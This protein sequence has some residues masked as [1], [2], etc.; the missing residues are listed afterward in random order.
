M[1]FG[2]IFLAALLAVL[3]GGIVS[4]LFWMMVVAG[5]MGS[6]E[7]Q[8][9]VEENS[10]LQIDFTEQI[11]D[12]PSSDPLS[13][14]DFTTLKV[15]PS[16]SLYQVLQA[17]DAARNDDRIKG[18]YIRPKGVG[19]LEIAVLEELRTALKEFKQS[20]KF[21]V[22]YGEMY[23]QG[24]YYLASVADKIFLQK[25]GMISWQGLAMTTVFFKGLFD[26]LGIEYEIY[27]PTSCKYK[28]AVEPYFLK[29]MS[30]P[31]REQTQQIIDS[32]WEVLASD[33]AADRGFDL[34]QFNTLTD[35]LALSMP[36]DALKNGMV[37]GLI[38][39]DEMEAWFEEQGVE[40][41]AD[42]K[43]NFISLGSY[44]SQLAPNIENLTA[45]QVAILYA[46][47]AI[48][49]G[50]GSE[51]GTIYGNTLAAEVAALRHNEDVK[52][53][54]LRV[55]SPGGSALASDVIWREITLLQAQKP[56]IISMGSYAASGGYYISAPADAILANRLTLTG[57]IGVFGAFPIV[58]EMLE[59][60]LG[61]TLDG[62]KSNTSGDFGQT[63]LIGSSRPSTPLEKQLFTRSVDKVY[64]SFTTK[65]ASGRNLPL[66]R[67]LEIAEGRVW[68]GVDALEI[69]LVD[70]NGG[71]K[72]AIA[73][74]A[75]KAGLSDYRVEEH[76]P[77]A[78]GLSAILS[79][80]GAHI[81]NR[82]ELNT[83]GEALL[84]YKK[85]REVLDQQGLLMYSPYQ[86]S[87][88]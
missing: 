45:P 37:D 76:L 23:E 51:S 56:V 64:E 40:R 72:E 19:A 32:M 43:F 54:V 34:A 77:A 3:V 22:A 42:R 52:A 48:V 86:Y 21:I 29:E 38:Y 15:T 84:P 87:I 25:E 69:G 24:H 10:I 62:V 60:K 82:F 30:Q 46:D 14:F 33:V 27:R 6:M 83:L 4:F 58:G 75:E 63:I 31:N 65:V 81:Q 26:K 18:I 8:P 11:S 36:A 70:G 20:G 55:N 59:K 74:A 28:S 39:E 12:A 50:E 71:L 79:S 67:V 5:F 41:N 68:S 53:V 57:S 1:K 44:A 61:I 47:G 85:A 17:V 2:K 78:D 88:F 16:L 73:I 13:G 49:D 66:E 35:G 80:L 9:L 7:S